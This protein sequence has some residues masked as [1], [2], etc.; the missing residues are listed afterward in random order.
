M[1]IGYYV[2]IVTN[3]LTKLIGGFNRSVQKRLGQFEQCQLHALFSPRWK[4]VSI[5]LSPLSL[6]S[7][8]IC[9]THAEGRNEIAHEWD[10]VH[11][12]M[13][14]RAA[15]ILPKVMGKSCEL[16]ELFLPAHNQSCESLKKSLWPKHFS[17]SNFCINKLKEMGTKRCAIKLQLREFRL[18]L[19]H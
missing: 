15:I 9:I 13:L 7:K 19:Y 3:R 17:K 12:K 18:L 2:W 16:D 4:Y 11:L 1:T 6:I 5:E 14:S 8:I 10:N